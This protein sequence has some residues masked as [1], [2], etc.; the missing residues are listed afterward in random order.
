MVHI[1]IEA[2]TAQQVTAETPGHVWVEFVEGNGARYTYGHYPRARPNLLTM[3]APGCFR[4]PDRYHE[5]CKDETLTFNVTREQYRRALDQA[6]YYCQ[7]TP[8]FNVQSNNCTSIA[9]DILGFAG[10]HLP[11]HNGP[12]GSFNLVCDN[13]H[14][15]LEAVRRER[16]SRTA[17]TSGGPDA[18]HQR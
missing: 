1:D 13:P 18:G 5:R 14:A 11:A 10:L 4:H 8:N 17:P 6:Q 15:L 7:N 16:R 3:T 12:V 9:A 2:T